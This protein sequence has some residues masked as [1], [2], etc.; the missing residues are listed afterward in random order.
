MKQL[1]PGWLPGR[2]DGAGVVLERPR[3]PHSSDYTVCFR[4]QFARLHRVNILFRVSTTGTRPLLQFGTSFKVRFIP[5]EA[6]MSFF[7]CLSFL[8]LLA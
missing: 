7:V 3:F 5:V 6:C 4:F 8:L 2:G 1:A